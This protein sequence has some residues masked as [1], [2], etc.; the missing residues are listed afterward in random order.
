[1]RRNDKQMCKDVKPTPANDDRIL[2]RA[3]H[4]AAER[5]DEDELKNSPIAVLVVRYLQQHNL[6]YSNSNC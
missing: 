1:M 4:T 2:F 6:L 3:H 5:T